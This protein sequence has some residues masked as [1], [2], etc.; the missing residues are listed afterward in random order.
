MRHVSAIFV[1]TCRQKFDCDGCSTLAE[2]VLCVEGRVLA[3][4]SIVLMCFHR[5]LEE[6]FF[7]ESCP[8]WWCF[9]FILS[10]FGNMFCALV[11]CLV[12]G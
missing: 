6:A 10:P 7:L 1:A 9:I 11:H 4:L 5:L 12:R 3:R 8:F 2:L